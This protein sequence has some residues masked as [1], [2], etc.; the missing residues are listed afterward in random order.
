MGTSLGVRMFYYMTIEEREH[1]L[2]ERHIAGQ[3][4]ITQFR[5]MANVKILGHFKNQ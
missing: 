5:K 4:R 3:E 1:F 2:G